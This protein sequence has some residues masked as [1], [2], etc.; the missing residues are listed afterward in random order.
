MRPPATTSEDAATFDGGLDQWSNCASPDFGGAR[1][2]AH[3]GRGAPQG[4]GKPDEIRRLVAARRAAGV[5]PH[6]GAADH[7]PSRRAGGWADDTARGG[8]AQPTV[9]KRVDE[10]FGWWKTGGG[11]RKTRYRGTARVRLP[12]SW[13]AAAHTL[14]RLAKLLPAPA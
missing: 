1:H 3:R 8:G 6:G 12:T 14:L 10:L 9:R 11:L 4:A 2:R 13:V 7:G 5:T